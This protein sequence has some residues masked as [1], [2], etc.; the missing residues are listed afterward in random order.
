M[1]KNQFKSKKT[2]IYLKRIFMQPWFD[3]NFYSNE[4]RNKK[5]SQKLRKNML[6]AVENRKVV[7]VSSWNI[8]FKFR[9]SKKVTEYL[10]SGGFLVFYPG[11]FWL[12]Y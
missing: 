12:I 1:E 4:P 3:S 9:L 11:I 7:V 10:C 5:A 2:F 8:Y 6:D